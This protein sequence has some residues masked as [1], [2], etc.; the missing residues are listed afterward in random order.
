MRACGASVAPAAE[1]VN[2][3]EAALEHGAS[4]AVEFIA[5]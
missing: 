2:M 5:N 3:E 1:G 4:G